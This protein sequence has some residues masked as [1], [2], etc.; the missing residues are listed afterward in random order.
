MNTLGQL[1]TVLDI[2]LL[3]S[4]SIDKNQLNQDNNSFA[5][6][7]QQTVMSSVNSS[8][9]QTLDNNTLGAIYKMQ[10][11]HSPILSSQSAIQMASNIHATVKDNTKVPE[12][13]EEI[14]QKASEVYNL[15]AKL[16]KSIIKHESNFNSSAVSHAGASGLMQ[17]MPQTAKGLGVSDIFDPLQNVMGGSKYLRTM[18]DKYDGNLVL[19]LAAY[20]AGPG[21]VDKYGGIPPFTE[22]QN[23]VRKVTETFYS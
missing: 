9:P 7:L 3:K 1:K 16:I 15:P 20:N 5:Q 14:I 18:L 12:S 13:L 22:T 2:Q 19:A 6:L 21:N 11:N 17:L 8:A 23:Y 4:F 10:L